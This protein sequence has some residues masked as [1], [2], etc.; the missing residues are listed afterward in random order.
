[1]HLT[2]VQLKLAGKLAK[3]EGYDGFVDVS[4]KVMQGRTALEQRLAVRQVLL[5]LLPPGAPATV[6]C[7]TDFQ[8]S[9]ENPINFVR[10]ARLGLLMSGTPFCAGN[11]VHDLG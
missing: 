10:T 8:V 4:K 7:T 5:S 6:P 1:M 9:R 2:E 11:E 3:V